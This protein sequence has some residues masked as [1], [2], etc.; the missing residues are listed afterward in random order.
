MGRW[1]R[2]ANHGRCLSHRAH[3]E[4]ARLLRGRGEAQ[5]DTFVRAPLSTRAALPCLNFSLHSLTCHVLPIVSIIVSQYVCAAGKT[6]SSP[7]ST[8]TERRRSATAMCSLRIR[9]SSWTEPRVGSN[10]ARSDAWITLLMQRYI[11]ALHTHATRKEL[12]WRRWLTL[13]PALLLFLRLS[14]AAIPQGGGKVQGV[15][16][17][18]DEM[19]PAPQ[20]GPG[21]ARRPW[22]G[23]GAHRPPRPQCQQARAAPREQRLQEEVSFAG[24]SLTGVLVPTWWRVIVRPE[25]CGR[26]RGHAHDAQPQSAE[27]HGVRPSRVEAELA[28]YRLHAAQAM[29]I[30]RSDA[31]AVMHLHVPSSR[32][33]GIR[34]TQLRHRRVSAAICAHTQNLPKISLDCRR[35]LYRLCGF[36]DSAIAPTPPPH[37]HTYSHIHFDALTHARTQ[38]GQ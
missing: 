30:C 27:S 31:F 14:D 8:P 20:S 17:H 24:E 11:K 4:P 12:L 26:E 2:H 16:E 36:S 13:F 34:Q 29:P 7:Q 18:G 25:P 38:L 33:K 5:A 6:A 21:R 10:R 3:A 15:G 32:P 22:A 9:K 1:R 37:T 23:E 19:D 35:L 28:A